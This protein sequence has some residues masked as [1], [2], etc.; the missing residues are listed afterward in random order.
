M[1]G[2]MQNAMRLYVLLAIY[3]GRTASFWLKM[4]LQIFQRPIPS[5][6]W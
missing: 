6:N 1:I 4:I 3:G 5:A 2:D